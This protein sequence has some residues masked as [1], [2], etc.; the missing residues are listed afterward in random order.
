MPGGR[1]VASMTCSFCGHWNCEGEHRCAHCGRRSEGGSAGSLNGSGLNT[2]QL[3]EEI[4]SAVQGDSAPTAA[5]PSWKREVEE[6]VGA[7]L[8]RRRAG[9]TEGASEVSRGLASE[10]EPPLPIDPKEAASD[11]GPASE[12]RPQALA[13][14][15]GSQDLAGDSDGR[16]SVLEESHP[17][18]AADQ[19]M[20]VG[21]GYESPFAEGGGSRGREVASASPVAPVA[22]RAVAGLLGLAVVLI[23]LGMLL[24]LFHLMGGALVPGE[25]SARAILISFLA[26]LLFYWLFCVETGAE[27]PGM[28]W[29]GLRVVSFDGQSLTA[30]QRFTRAWA[31]VL[32]TTALGLGFVWSLADEEKLTWHDRLSK[33]F[34]TQDESADVPHVLRAHH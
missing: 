28:R 16:R 30:R 18:P 19:P 11:R 1:W 4:L 17:R 23:S 24:T 12:A 25:E 3:R 21:R 32:S 26:L 14:N 29:V 15:A 10:S 7:Y 33:T 6:K 13:D 27:T 20:E 34:L 2:G 22:I 8:Q 9:Q 31:T 5:A